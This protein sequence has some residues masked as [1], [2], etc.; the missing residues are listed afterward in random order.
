MLASSHPS[1]KPRSPAIGGITNTYQHA[2]QTQNL[3]FQPHFTNLPTV[4]TQPCFHATFCCFRCIC[5]LST[6]SQNWLEGSLSC[7]CSFSCFCLCSHAPSCGT[8]CLHFKEFAAPAYLFPAHSV[9][10]QTYD[11][12]PGDMVL[13]F[14]PSYIHSSLQCRVSFWL[15]KKHWNTASI[16]RSEILGHSP[17]EL[18]S[19]A[20]SCAQFASSCKCAHT[21]KPGIFEPVSQNTR[22]YLI[23]PSLLFVG[24]DAA[25]TLSFGT[26][27]T[28]IV[29]FSQANEMQ[30][31]V[32]LY[33]FLKCF[34]L[35]FIIFFWLISSSGCWCYCNSQHGAEVPVPCAGV[36]V[37][38][39]AGD[40]GKSTLCP[41]E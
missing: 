5:C 28:A 31:S 23:T 2:E 15:K 4:Q 38:L 9:A 18:L 32:C 1:S 19:A 37:P 7:A 20:P 41:H 40:G 13:G 11:W 21:E 34:S 8:W 6:K 33:V 27:Q 30:P 12:A 24:P 26:Q 35:S 3:K 39:W 29:M 17:G 25:V 36:Q 22:L 14:G 10:M 16:Y